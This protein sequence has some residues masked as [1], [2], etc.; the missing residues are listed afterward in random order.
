MRKWVLLTHNEVHII[1]R[2]V[3]SST[4]QKEGRE[5]QS[6]LFLILAPN[7]ELINFLGQIGNGVTGPSPADRPH[8]GLLSYLPPPDQFKCYPFT[9]EVSSL[10]TVTVNPCPKNLCWWERRETARHITPDTW[11]TAQPKSMATKSSKQNCNF[12]NDLWFTRLDFVSNKLQAW[13]DDL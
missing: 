10:L 2:Q 13:P 8:T 7:I 4:L 1:T 3:G 6:Q 12:C 11:H 9:W 5:K